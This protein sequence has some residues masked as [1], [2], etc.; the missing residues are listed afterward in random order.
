MLNIKDPETHR[1]ARELADIEGTSLT[2]AVTNAL[3]V[4]LA[5]HAR[6]RLVRRQT[7]TA[8]VNS[9]REMGVTPTTD[10]IAELYDPETGLPR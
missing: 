7:L 2:N 1:L 6:R 9:A 8:L 10:P 3:R 5:E 4:A